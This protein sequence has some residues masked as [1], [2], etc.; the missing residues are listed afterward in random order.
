MNSNNSLYNKIEEK[1][2]MKSKNILINIKS[3]YFIRKVF[4]NI[5]KIKILNII[6]YYRKLQ[7]LLNYNINN[8]KEYS[9][10][11]SSIK[12]GMINLSIL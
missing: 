4:D 6:K 11:Y 9:E 5:K 8:Y 10:L 3:D 1:I 2:K 7:E 12:I